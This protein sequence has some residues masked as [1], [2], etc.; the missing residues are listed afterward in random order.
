M[1]RN[2]K[3]VIWFGWLGQGPCSSEGMVILKP[4]LCTWDD[5]SE[6]VKLFGCTVR[7]KGRCTVQSETPNCL[8][9][10]ILGMASSRESVG[11]RIWTKG[12]TQLRD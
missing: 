10:T 4:Y 11:D 7:N 1:A 12:P 6:A 2:R 5:Q 9:I 8:T 3:A